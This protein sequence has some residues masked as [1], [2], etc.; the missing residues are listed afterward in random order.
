MFMTAACE[1]DWLLWKETFKSSQ[2]A[3]HSEWAGQER[4]TVN[5]LGE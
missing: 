5:H 3:A 4:Y 2:E 1:L